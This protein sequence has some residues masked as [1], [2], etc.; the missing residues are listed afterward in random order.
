M[1]V[2]SRLGQHITSLALT[3]QRKAP[4]HDFL[5]AMWNEEAARKHTPIIRHVS[6]C[7]ID[8][9]FRIRIGKRP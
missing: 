7:I 5:R 9:L 4:T 2:S 6:G 1:R 8:R 3:G